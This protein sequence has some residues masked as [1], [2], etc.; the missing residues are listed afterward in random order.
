MKGSRLSRLIS[1]LLCAMLVFSLFP[2]Q[3]F[4]DDGEDA[5]PEPPASDP[6][7]VYTVS[8]VDW[9]GSAIASVLVK[10]GESATPPS[11]PER[12]G[13]IADGWD[14]SLSDIQSDLKVTALYKEATDELSLEDMALAL[15]AAPLANTNTGSYLHLCRKRNDK[16]S[17]ALHHVFG[18]RWKY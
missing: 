10:Q 18:E 1:L 16:S 12:E 11:H 5:A 2:A 9:D 6:V 8:F 4:A 14:K 3:A 7:P 15:M 13:Y 17:P